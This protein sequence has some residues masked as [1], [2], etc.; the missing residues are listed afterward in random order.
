MDYVVSE[1]GWRRLGFATI[2]DRA[3]AV[4]ELADSAFQKDLLKAARSLGIVDE[5]YAVPEACRKN[6]Y[7]ELVKRFGAI[8]KENVY[9]LGLGIALENFATEAERSLIR[10]GREGAGLLMKLKLLN[11]LNRER[12]WA[13]AA[14]RSSFAQLGDIRSA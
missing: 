12:T 6:T 9:P 1:Y 3:K 7:A 8:S 2:S 4:I 14:L 11:A 13:H 10:A 5:S